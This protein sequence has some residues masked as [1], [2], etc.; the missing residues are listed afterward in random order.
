MDI[1]EAVN[2]APEW[3]THISIRRY[4]NQPDFFNSV[5]FSQNVESYAKHPFGKA[6]FDSIASGEHPSWYFVEIPRTLENE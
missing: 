1:Q 2:T 5:E 4:D 6:L 3:A